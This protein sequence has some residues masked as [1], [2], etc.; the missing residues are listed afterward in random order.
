MVRKLSDI[1][2][3]VEKLSTLL[4][5]Q[6][7]HIEQVILYGSWAVNRQNESSDIDLVIISKDLKRFTYLERLE[8]L[9]I[10]SWK[11]PA[12][13]EIIGYTPEEIKN[14]GPDSIFWEEIQATGKVIYKAA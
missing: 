10:I 13:L 14:K 12:P 4:E 8:F 1:K 2:K 3:I 6:G 11:L 5:K 9:S 7:I